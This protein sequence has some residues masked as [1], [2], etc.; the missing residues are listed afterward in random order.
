MLSH[1]GTHGQHL[2]PLLAHRH[3][4]LGLALRWSG[5]SCAKRTCAQLARLLKN[6]LGQSETAQVDPPAACPVMEPGHTLPARPTQALIPQITQLPRLEIACGIAAHLQY[7][8]L[9]S[10]PSCVKACSSSIC[11][12]HLKRQIE[13]FSRPG[14]LSSVTAAFLVQ[15]KH[16]DTITAL[17]GNACRAELKL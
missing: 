1:A 11:G 14:L 17:S 12:T 8:R 15:C 4:Q 3:T 7:C 10:H 16:Q 9:A 6:L 5:L 2:H 13:H